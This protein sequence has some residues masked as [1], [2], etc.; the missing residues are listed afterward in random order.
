[1]NSVSVQIQ[2]AIN[3]A[4]SNQILP[5]NQNALKAGSGQLT[6]KG[7]NVAAERPEYDAEDYRNE[8]IRSNSKSEPVRNRLTDDHIDQAYDHL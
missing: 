2:R 5:Q 4:I 8:R 3:D 7:W 6:Q 1:M